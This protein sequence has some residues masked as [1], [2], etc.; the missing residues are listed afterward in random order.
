[1]KEVD[2]ESNERV[3]NELLILKRNNKVLK[4]KYEVLASEA[5]IKD[6]RITKLEK[7]VDKYKAKYKDVKNKLSELPKNMPVVEE[8]FVHIG[9]HLMV[10]KS[11][12][13]LFRSTDYSKYTGDLMEVVFGMEKLSTHVLKIIKGCQKTEVLDVNIISD[14]E[15]HVISKFNVTKP[16]VR[17]AM[18]LKLNY[19]HKIKRRL[20]M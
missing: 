9:T 7:K 16:Q 11:K 19:A 10:P 12:Q 18:R 15:L 8:E 1:M 17:Y 6:E 5:L 20:S 4:R 13:L 2:T 14:I 3:N